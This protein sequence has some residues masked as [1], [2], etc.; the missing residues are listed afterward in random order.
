MIE[1]STALVIRHK[2]SGRVPRARR[3][4]Q[5]HNTRDEELAHVGRRWWMLAYDGLRDD[6]G[7]GR[8][9]AGGAITDKFTEIDRRLR[10]AARVV[11]ELLEKDEG[12]ESA[13]YR[14]D[15]AVCHGVA[16]PGQRYG[17]QRVRHRLP[18]QDRWY[19]GERWIVVGQTV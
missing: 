15:R 2:K 1:K 3:A 5:L 14:R 11:Q 19:R 7:D 13:N 17:V 10:Q 12:I 9:G 6:P 4:Q 16:L 8:Q 18:V